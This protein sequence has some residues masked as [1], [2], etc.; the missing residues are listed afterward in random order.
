MKETT[1]MIRKMDM[2][3]SHGQNWMVKQ[4]PKFTMVVGKMANN[5]ELVFGSTSLEKAIMGL[6]VMEKLK[7]WV[8]LLSKV[9]I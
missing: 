7:E 4:M 8:L 6:G 9:N 5:M 3:F 1:L 2:V